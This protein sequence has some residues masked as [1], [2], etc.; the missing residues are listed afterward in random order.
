MVTDMVDASVGPKSE[1]EGTAYTTAEK[2]ET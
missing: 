2:G 1:K